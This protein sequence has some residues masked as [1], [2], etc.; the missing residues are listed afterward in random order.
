MKEKDEI[1]KSFILRRQSLDSSFIKGAGR[2]ICFHLDNF[3]LIGEAEQMA[4]FHPAKGEPDICSFLNES[5]KNGRKTCFPRFNRSKGSYEMAFV[6]DFAE[7]FVEGE[8]GIPEPGPGAPAASVGILKNILWLVPG[9]AF[10]LKGG[11]LGHGR[12]I[13]DRLLSDAS[14]IKIGICYDWQVIDAVPSG[15]K[16]VKMDF[17]VTES[18]S[19]RCS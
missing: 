4:A 1:R 12:G 14:G 16:D 17:I 11:R 6:A 19:H 8:F 2:K 5:L 15:K 18:G 7:D 10:D 3:K 9:T 13:F